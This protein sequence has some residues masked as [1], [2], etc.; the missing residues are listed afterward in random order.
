[1]GILYIFS[2]A[3]SGIGR[4]TAVYFAELGAKL[5]ITGRDGDELE[6][7]QNLCQESNKS[8]PE[9]TCDD[10]NPFECEE[11]SFSSE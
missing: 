5:V 9:V 10:I 3:S 7:T 4:A 8:I 2:G 11:I 1:M 6:K